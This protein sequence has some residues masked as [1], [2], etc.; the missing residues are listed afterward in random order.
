MLRP[1]LSWR[2]IFHRNPA[3]VHHVLRHWHIQLLVYVVLLR[4]A[5]RLPRGRLCLVGGFFAIDERIRLSEEA[6]HCRMKYIFAKKASGVVF[7]F[8]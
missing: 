4:I 5:N 2:A 8:V 3:G 1:V 6:S 7:V